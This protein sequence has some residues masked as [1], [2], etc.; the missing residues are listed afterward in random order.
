MRRMGEN[1]AIPGLDPAADAGL[2]ADPSDGSKLHSTWVQARYGRDTEIWERGR[3]QREI[4]GRTNAIDTRDGEESSGSGWIPEQRS[5]GEQCARV[6][7]R[8]PLCTPEAEV[9]EHTLERTMCCRF[10]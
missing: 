2:T 3:Q 9:L 4:N 5:A 8:T 1:S 6:T 10:P 7:K